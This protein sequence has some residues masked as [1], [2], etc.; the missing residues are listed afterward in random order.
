M[1]NEPDL[2]DDIVGIIRGLL[3]GIGLVA[4]V[5]VVCFYFGYSSPPATVPGK[6]LGAHSMGA[7]R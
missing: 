1:N 7:V 2:M 5:L 6:A 4:T 3:A